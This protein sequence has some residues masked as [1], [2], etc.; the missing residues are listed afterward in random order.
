MTANNEVLR[1]L[2]TI[3]HDTAVRL[4]YQFEIDWYE[5]VNPAALTEQQFLREA[6]WVVLSSGF[7]ESVVR[8]HFPYLSI[9]FH[10]WESAALIIEDA[11]TC[12]GLARLRFCNERKLKAIV[13][14][15]KILATHGYSEF[16]KNLNCSP[17]A[18]LEEL[19]FIGPVTSLHLAK[20]LGFQVAKPDRHLQR[21]A[22]NF[23]YE[24]VHR[25]CSDISQI[26]MKSVAVVDTV[27]WRF[28]VLGG[29]RMI[30]G[31][32]I[33]GQ[34]ELTPVVRTL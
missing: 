29:F 22:S 4:G 1:R 18:A 26:T 31:D 28:C 10:D 27:L 11:K 25:F 16:K 15:A 12:I 33:R 21:L 9:C 5:R 6:A 23:G 13:S 7:R 3:A 14:I 24:D 20:N 19:P 2:F 17:L 32:H 8:R 30:N 34:S